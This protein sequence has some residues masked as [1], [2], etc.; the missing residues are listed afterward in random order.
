MGNFTSLPYRCAKSCGLLVMKSPT[1]VLFQLTIGIDNHFQSID[2]PVDIYRY[3]EE[4]LG[5][6]DE[7]EKS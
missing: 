2:D 7:L 6:I 3:R 5:R 4:I 1:V